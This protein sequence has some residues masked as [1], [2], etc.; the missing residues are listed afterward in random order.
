MKVGGQ[1]HTETALSPW[2]SSHYTLVCV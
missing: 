2:K 1:Y